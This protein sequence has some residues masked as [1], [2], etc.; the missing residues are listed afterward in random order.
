MTKVLRTLFVTIFVGA[1]GAIGLTAFN[2]RVSM[3]DPLLDLPLTL[4]EECRYECRPCSLGHDIVESVNRNAGA[5]HLENCNPGECGSHGCGIEIASRASELWSKMR[6]GKLDPREVLLEYQDIASYNRT[7]N[8]VQIRCDA[9][10]IA[11]IPLTAVQV[12]ILEE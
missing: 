8:A 9:G 1:V 4:G 10:L 7:R 5:S 11:S 3:A 12:A 6:I 2:A